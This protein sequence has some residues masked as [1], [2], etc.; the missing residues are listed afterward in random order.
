MRNG[1][2]TPGWSR[3]CVAAARS[4]SR[5]S[6]EV[7]DLASCAKV[8]QTVWVD[9]DQHCLSLPV[10]Q[11]A[12][13]A[14]SPWAPSWSSTWPAW[15]R[16][17]AQRCGTGCRC[18]S[19]PAPWP[20]TS[21]AWPGPAERAPP[22]R[23]GWAGGRSRWSGC[24]LRRGERGRFHPACRFLSNRWHRWQSGESESVQQ[25]HHLSACR[26]G[27]CRSS[28]FPLFP[29]CTV[30]KQMEMKKRFRSLYSEV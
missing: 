25:T 3:S 18:G 6:Q 12:A 24:S 23:T 8:T 27:K 19:P 17:R 15:R 11:K 20:G 1:W 21:R 4:P 10:E 7:N 14:A 16:R 26:R 9:D 29:A 28:S 22:G 30:R 2:L 13:H 5:M